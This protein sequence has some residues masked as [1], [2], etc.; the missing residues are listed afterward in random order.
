MGGMVRTRSFVLVTACCAIACSDATA[1][2]ETVELCFNAQTT[3]VGVQNDGSDWRSVADGPGPVSVRLTDRVVIGRTLA[4][5]VV[6]LGSTLELF[7]LTREQARAR[8]ACADGTNALTG[9]VTNIGQPDTASAIVA[10]ANRSVGTNGSYQL[11]GVPDGPQDLLATH[12]SLAIIRRAQTYADGST[13]PDLDFASAEAFALQSN[14]LT[15][16]AGGLPTSYWFTDFYSHRGTRSTLVTSLQ[17]CCRTRLYSVPETRLE[18][19]DLQHMYVVAGGGA[20]L[21]LADR[22]YVAPVDQ[23]ID[24]GPPANHPV[25]NTAE[26][27]TG[28]LWRVD[29]TSHAE[30]PGQVVIIAY[31]PQPVSITVIRATR[32]Y[33]GSTPAKW[34]FRVPDLSG[35]PG[36]SDF[37]V[38]LPSS[39]ECT[40]SA[41]PWLMQSEAVAGDTFLSAYAHS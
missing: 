24:M 28:Q 30:Y 7:Y 25:F 21:R 14:A 2:T 17:R 41:R 26:H 27:V 4:G 8:F 32:E 39:W 35:V 6:S 12:D 20:D 10:L 34:T 13:I 37:Q 18:A 40:E 1:P 15:V 3:W 36:F 33:F 29:L 16:N 5:G 11:T 19:G 9:S 22:F 38:T 23:T 31:D